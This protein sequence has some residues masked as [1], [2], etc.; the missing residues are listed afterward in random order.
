MRIDISAGIFRQVKEA[1]RQANQHVNRGEYA[2]A[3]KQ[4]RLCYRLMQQYAD[5]AVGETVRRMRLDEAEKYLARAT[6]L[7][8]RSRSQAAPI[9]VSA[10]AERSGSSDYQGIIEG[11]IT[12]VNV[13][14]HDIGGLEETKAEIQTSFALGLVQVPAG[15]QIKA[16]RNLLLYGPPGTGKTMLAGAIS[17]ELDATF[18]NARIPDLLSQY[19]GESSKLISALYATAVTHAPSVVFLDELD[20]LTRQRG[21]GAESGAERRV[22]NTLL[23]ELDG[24]QHKG[25]DLP[26]VMTVGATNVPWELDRAILSRFS[27]GRIYVPLPDEAA[28]RQIL[29]IHLTRQGHTST[30]SAGDLVRKMAGYSGREMERIVGLA[31]QG[32]LRRANPDLLQRTTNGQDALRSYQ[33]RVE[34][35]T[36][37]DFDAALRQVRPAVD[38]EE[39]RRYEA[40]RQL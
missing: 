39:A 38:A 29:D 1:E 34:P 17:N 19:F 13:H 33:L 6:Q 36:A 37:V 3:A 14:W 9:T 12:R 30:V 11:L 23:G 24:L 7:D 40:W 25:G 8:E 27:G 10:V 32:M 5:Y 2:E 26:L 35:L 21:G 18:F 22:L 28:R 16:N 20:A 31:V 4:Y 15:V